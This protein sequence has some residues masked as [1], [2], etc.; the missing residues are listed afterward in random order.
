MMK[1]ASPRSVASIKVENLAGVKF[2]A[3]GIGTNE[4]PKDNQS[5]HFEN[6]FRD[7]IIYTQ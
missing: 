4:I 1:S 6:V 7:I 5:M 2:T 3:H